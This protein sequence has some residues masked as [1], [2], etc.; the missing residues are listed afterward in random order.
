MW[1]RFKVQ[2]RSQAAA[3]IRTAGATYA[4]ARLRGRSSQRLF[5]RRTTLEDRR[6]TWNLEVTGW[7]IEAVVTLER[8]KQDAAAETDH[9]PFA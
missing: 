9:A 2:R 4:R 8:F 6:R 3:F 5:P 7:S 1:C